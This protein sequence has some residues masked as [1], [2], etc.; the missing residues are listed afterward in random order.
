[1]VFLNFIF[2][3]KM[4]RNVIIPK[5]VVLFQ[6]DTISITNLKIKSSNFPSI[7]F[8]SKLNLNSNYL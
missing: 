3:K 4:K 5:N 1:M 7:T 2:A 6:N 8:I